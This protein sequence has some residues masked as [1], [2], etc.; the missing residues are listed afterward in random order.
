MLIGERTAEDIKMS[1]GS[2]YERPEP[3]M[4]EVRGRNLLTRDAPR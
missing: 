3:V 4:A 1:I 2:V